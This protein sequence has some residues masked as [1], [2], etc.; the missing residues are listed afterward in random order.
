MSSSRKKAIIRKYSRDW[1]AGYLP[2]AGFSNGGQLEILDL[3]GK[4]TR[5]NLEEV[6]WVCFVRDFNSGEP[7]NPE[8]LLRKTF[9]GRPRGEGI[10]LRLRLKDNEQLEGIAANDLSLIE[11][12]GIF[13]TP[14]DTRSNTQRIFLP[15]TSVAEMEVVAVIS[16]SGKRKSIGPELQ[17]SLFSPRES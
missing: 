4:V 5:M 13:L 11:N 17:E 1:L 7:T 14:P 9:A 2:V 6:K 12:E 15:R 16:A 3:D 8:R 10:W